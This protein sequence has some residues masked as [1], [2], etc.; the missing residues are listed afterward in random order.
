MASE[1]LFYAALA[2]IATGS[3]L[4]LPNLPGQI[5]DIYAADDPRRASAFSVY[6]V[7]INTGALIAPLVCGTI[8]ELYGWHWGF[9]V[10][11]IGMMVGLATYLLGSRYLPAGH[12]ASKART[13]GEGGRAGGHRDRFRLLILIA[14]VV[15]VLRAAYEQIGNT[16]AVWLQTGVDRSVAHASVPMT[17]FQSLNP[18]LVFI[19]TPL[20]VLYWARRA[21][22][23]REMSPMVKMV[24]GASLVC[25]AYLLLV[26]LTAWAGGARLWWPWAVLFFVLITAG[27]L[28]VFPIGLDL[29]ARLAPAGFTATAIAIWY[30]AGFAGNLLAGVVGSFWSRLSHVDFFA[31]AAFLAGA[32]AL[33]LL[34]FDRQVG[35]GRS[36]SRRI[37]SDEPLSRTA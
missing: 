31:A 16:I 19:L 22:R 37:G 20:L 2:T 5:Q 15:T 29:F 14:A 18:L 10:A 11:G 24:I 27:E 36:P 33:L 30:L 32:S 21:G 17:W 34:V 13:P 3:G 35:R 25:L 6:Y 8:G 7:G 9:T 1:P 4:L 26:S 12:A 23:G 28:F